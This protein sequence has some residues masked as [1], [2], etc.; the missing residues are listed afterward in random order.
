M[1][2]V[3]IGPYKAGGVE[4]PE[5]W[6]MEWN[7]ALNADIDLDGYTVDVLYRVNNGDQVVLDDEASLFDAATGR[8]IVTWSAADFATAGIMA[9]EIVV[10]APGGVPRMAETFQCVILPARG[11]TW[12]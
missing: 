10:T 8:T 12:P 6:V 9:G 5:P 3:T 11:G 4:I 7:D 1:S 2:F